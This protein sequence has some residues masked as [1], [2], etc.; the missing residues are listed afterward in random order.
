VYRK[1]GQWAGEGETE[2]VQWGKDHAAENVPR[3][4][5]ALT[6]DKNNK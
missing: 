1:I 6:E 4:A 2:A 5:D 3:L